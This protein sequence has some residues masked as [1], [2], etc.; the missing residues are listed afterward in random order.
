MAFSQKT[1]K[2]VSNIIFGHVSPKFL[3]TDNLHRIPGCSGLID[4]KIIK[5]YDVKYLALSN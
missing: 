3:T 5:R 1:F 4:V 2:V